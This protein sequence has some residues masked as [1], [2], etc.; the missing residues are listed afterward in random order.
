MILYGREYQKKVSIMEKK[1]S[2]MEGKC[3]FI[4][5]ICSAAGVA[6]SAWEPAGAGADH[7]DVGISVGTCVGVCVGLALYLLGTL[8]GPATP[9]NRH[10]GRQSVF[11][12]RK[13]LL[14]EE[15]CTY[16]RKLQL[17]EENCNLLN[18][19]LIYAGKTATYGIKAIV[20]NRFLKRKEKQNN[21]F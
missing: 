20:I 5:E 17:M 14:V 1:V 21:N 8:V 3:W 6:G 15:L 7:R 4:D 16:G 9:A 18:R 11:L 13:L 12:L 2:F 19:N 10:Y